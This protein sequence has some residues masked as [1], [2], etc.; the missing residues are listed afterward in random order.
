MKKIIVFGLS[1]VLLLLNLRV[2]SQD[3]SL[4]FNHITKEDG[5]SQSTIDGIVQDKYGFMWFATQDGLNRYDGY[6]FK[7]FRPDRSKESSISYN[8]ITSLILDSKKKYLGWDRSGFE[9]VCI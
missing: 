2:I 4:H 1:F 8:Y 3:I 7:I 5:L 9:P 6:D